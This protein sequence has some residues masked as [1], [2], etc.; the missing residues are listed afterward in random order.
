MLNVNFLTSAEG[1]DELNNIINYHVISASVT[2]DM[3]TNGLMLA[4]LQDQGQMVTFTVG[5]T[6]MVNNSTIVEADML[7]Y[8][9]VTHGIDKVLMPS[10][11]T[12]SPSMSPSMVPTMAPT[13]GGLALGA[14]FS[15][16]FAA[17]LAVA[18]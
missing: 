12:T 14:S 5:Y 7:A 16:L 15:A 17:V 6:L 3:V 13:S 2:S 1:L 8:N 18:L 11:D 9:G 4:T 10:D